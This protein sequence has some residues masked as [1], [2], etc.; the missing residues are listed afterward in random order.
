[1]FSKGDWV[2][3]DPG[4]GPKEIG[5]VAGM[6]PNGIDAFVCFS[7]GC[8][9]ARCDGSRL[10]LATDAGKV[11]APAGIGFHRFD[12]DCPVKDAEVCWA[13][14]PEKFKEVVG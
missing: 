9:A 6:A 12:D 3:Y 13:Y 4:Y 10:R 14:C 11:I 8:T 5:R 1:M 2:L 7:V